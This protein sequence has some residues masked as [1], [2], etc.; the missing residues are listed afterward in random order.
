[1][2]A[3]VSDERVQQLANE[4]IAMSRRTEDAETASELMKMSHR[5]LRLTDP[6]LPLWKD[7]LPKPRRLF[8]IW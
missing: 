7:P 1:M 3:M 2:H 4:C 6:T 8:G 5:I